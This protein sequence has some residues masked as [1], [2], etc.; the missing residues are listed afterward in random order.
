[1]YTVLIYMYEMPSKMLLMWI[2]LLRYNQVGTLIGRKE[3]GEGEEKMDNSRVELALK[4]NIE[5]D[6]EG[7]L[8]NTET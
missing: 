4:L 8:M 7:F 3:E 5:F 1:M 2:I 6:K